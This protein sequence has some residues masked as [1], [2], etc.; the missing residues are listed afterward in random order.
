MPGL[1][2]TPGPQPHTPD[3]N[4]LAPKSSWSAY[5]QDRQK[6]TWSERFR[7]R[8]AIPP[9]M[10]GRTLRAVSLSL[11]KTPMCRRVFVW[12]GVDM[13]YARAFIGRAGLVEVQ[14]FQAASVHVVKDVMAMGRRVRWQAQ[15]EGQL[16]SRRVSVNCHCRMLSF[17]DFKS[18]SCC[19]KPP[20]LNSGC[21][22]GRSVVQVRPSKRDRSETRHSHHG[23]LPECPPYSG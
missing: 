19:A 7:K 12:P 10:Q 17:S 21:V 20:P 16:V 1:A 11:S 13:A 23:R 6:Q 5:L 8:S 14:N 4:V 9:A 2:N 22:F 3:K 15:L 18:C